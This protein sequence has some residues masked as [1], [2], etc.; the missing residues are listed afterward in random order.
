MFHILLLP[1]DRLVSRFVILSHDRPF[2]HWDLLLEIDAGSPLLT[3]RILDDPGEGTGW[4]AEPLPDHRR[5]YLDYEG[6]ISGD[7]GTV[8]RWDAG[9]WIAVEPVRSLV[10]DGGIL[11]VRG[12]R[13]QCRLR[14]SPG[15]QFWTIELL[16]D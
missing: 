13:W 3:W 14:L 11:E 16:P 6:P 7:R 9:D 4:R 8:T 12:T 1:A 15:D 5:E 2:Q 10:D